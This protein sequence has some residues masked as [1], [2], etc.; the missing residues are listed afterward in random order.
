MPDHEPK[1][2]PRCGNGFECRLGSI[3]RCQCVDIALSDEMRE[4]IAHRYDDCLC[5]DCLMA[6]GKQAESSASTQSGAEA[7]AVGVATSAGSNA[8]APADEGTPVSARIRQRSQAAARARR[9]RPEDLI[10]IMQGPRR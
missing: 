9:V 5:R 8:A 6:L 3:H 4:S 10:R 2:C 7:S 1:R